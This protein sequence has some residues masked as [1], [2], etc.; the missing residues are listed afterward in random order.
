LH[1]YATPN[2]SLFL[3]SASSPPGAGV[4]GMCGWH[5]AER[6]LA[7]TLRCAS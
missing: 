2:P 1:P 3:C 5:A 7:G 6:A 4:H